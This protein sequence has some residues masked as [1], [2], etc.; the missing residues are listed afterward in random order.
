VSKQKIARRLVKFENRKIG[1]ITKL[2]KKN[3]SAGTTGRRLGSDRRRTVR[4]DANAGLVEDRVQSRE[5]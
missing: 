4:I 5:I 3:D 2:L 1:N